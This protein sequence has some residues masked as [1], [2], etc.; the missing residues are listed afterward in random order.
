MNSIEKQRPIGVFDSGV[1][2]ISVLKELYKLMPNETYL[3][4]G[5][6]ANAPYGI[7]D[8]EEVFQ[9]SH[10]IVEKFLQQNVK[11]IV[12]ACNTATSAAISRLRAE[13]PEII[14]IGLEPAVKPAIYHKKNSE[15]VVMATQLTLKEKKF[16]DLISHYENEAKIIPLPATKLVEFI[17]HGETNSLALKNYLKD[18]LAPYKETVD[19]IVLGCTHFPFARDAIQEIVG[20]QVYIVDGAQGAATRLQS[21]LKNNSLSNDLNGG[22]VRFYNSNPDP[23]E[24][25]LSRKLFS[26]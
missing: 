26:L 13:F 25:E 5:D 3:F 7:K 21:E 17:E 23:A 11:A 4:Y 22:A 2:G 12:I 15:V 8:T 24:I 14:F 20:N 19:S 18:L 10:N 6:S 1:G 16:A 9:L